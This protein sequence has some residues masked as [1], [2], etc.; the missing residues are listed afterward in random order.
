MK[1][2][3]DRTPEKI[4]VYV[5]D[6]DLKKYLILREAGVFDIRNGSAIINFNKYGEIG[7]II[8]NDTL[9]SARHSNQ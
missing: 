5:P 4:P 3:M 7:T 9:Y 8:R 2:T 1:C 6:E